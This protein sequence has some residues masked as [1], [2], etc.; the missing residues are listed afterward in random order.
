M[1]NNPPVKG[2]VTPL[3]SIIS[4]DEI[5]KATK[6]VYD[7]IAEKQQEFD[8]VKDFIADNSSHI[9]VVHDLPHVPFGKAAFFMGRTV[10]TNE[11]LV[12]EGENYY[13]DRTAKQT[14]DILKRRGK[15]L[16]SQVDSLKAN[17]EDLKA[18]A[19][20]FNSTASESIE[21]L[22]EIREE[23]PPEENLTETGHKSGKSFPCQL[24]QDSAPVSETK[25]KKK[26]E[27]AESEYSD[28][29][30]DTT[31]SD[32]GDIKDEQNM[33]A[34]FEKLKLGS[35]GHNVRYSGESKPTK[36][37]QQTKGDDK[38]T[39]GSN[40]YHLEEG[41]T[42][43]FTRT[44]LNNVRNSNPAQKSPLFPEVKQRVEAM[45]SSVT[46][47]SGQDSKPIHD[48]SK[49]YPPIAAFTGSIVEHSHNLQAPT[50]SQNP[51]AQPSKPVSRFKLQRR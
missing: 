4:P 28:E 48:S 33:A 39:L 50:S 25:N 47:V 2:T 15:A 26:S 45:P 23:L 8:R 35:S 46:T 27:L 43:Q 22:V 1:E 29:E 19:S 14:I 20:F 16:K 18:E 30:T 24:K 3:S 44:G 7:A 10:H 41:L 6:R 37:A 36:L 31:V 5:T 13:A 9:N 51:G 17:M 12:F 42:D 40:K 38:V 21:G 34:F 32:D 11:L 49:V